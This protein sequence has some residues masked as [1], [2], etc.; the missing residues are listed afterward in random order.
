MEP[1][2]YV[3]LIGAV[4]RAVSLAIA[5][6]GGICCIFLGWFLYRDGVRVAT[7]G[8]VD[9]KD[10][11]LKLSTSGPGVFLVAFGVGLLL[12]LVGQPATF[13]FGEP[14][15]QAT[16]H[17]KTLGRSQVFASSFGGVQNEIVDFRVSPPAVEQGPRLAEE[18]FN[19][20]RV[21]LVQ[22]S[23]AGPKSSSAGPA[24]SAGKSQACKPCRVWAI[25]FLD[26]P[27]RADQYQSAL[28]RAIALMTVARQHAQQKG[29][30][31]LLTDLRDEIERLR[32]LRSN[33]NDK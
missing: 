23:S 27:V 7:S 1:Q 26:G 6:L 24:A 9:H 18:R 19:K 11:K 21:V 33:L 10:F 31:Q 14:Q 22:A 2:D 20:N 3:V 12:Y 25:S 28:D 32:E 15:C 29:D 17:E 16:T 13:R 8:L 5:A 30:E 4:S